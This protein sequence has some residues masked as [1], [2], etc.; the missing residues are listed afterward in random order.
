MGMKLKA[1]VKQFFFLVLSGL[2]IVGFIGYSGVL[3]DPPL[4][5]DPW[6]AYGTALAAFLIGIRLLTMMA[7]PQTLFNTYGLF[8]YEDWTHFLC[9]FFSINVVWI[10]FFS[11]F[12]AFPQ[13]V[14]LKSSPLLAP[15]VCIRVVT[16][17]IY[18]KLVNDTV[19]KNMETLARVGFE[20]YLMQVVTD[21]SIQ[22]E[23]I[24]CWTR[25]STKPNISQFLSQKNRRSTILKYIKIVLRF[26]FALN[27]WKNRLGNLWM[28]W[29]LCS[30]F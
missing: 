21:Q 10:L 30:R 3:D 16:R 4:D 5:V 9:L 13:R 15:S 18:P 7:V 26:L 28:L 6:A 17:G 22:I 29:I 23:G 25:Y 8:R 1:S 24:Y 12:H 27:I 19:R 20:N 11:R 2:W 14:K